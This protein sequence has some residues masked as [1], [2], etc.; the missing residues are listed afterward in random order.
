MATDCSIML[1]S[2]HVPVAPSGSFNR[3]CSSSSSSSS[4]STDSEGVNHPHASENLR[5]V[6]SPNA[7][8]CLDYG[9]CV[10]SCAA[11][12]R[13]CPLSALAAGNAASVKMEAILA[14]SPLFQGQ[15]PIFPKT[16]K[17][18]DLVLGERLGEGG[19][20][21]VYGCAFKDAPLDES[22]AIKYLRPQI[23]SQKKSFEHGAADL[24]T[25]AF[26]L[27]K[28]NHPNIIKLRA[29]TTGSVESNVC[30]GKETGFFLVVDRLV[31]TVDQRLQRWR[32]QMDHTPHSLFHRM[33][34][35]FK[36][37][38]KA[39]LKERLKVASDIASVM[40]Y[41]HSLNVGEYHESESV[42]VEC[43]H[44]LTWVVPFS[45][46]AAYRDLKPD[47][48][49]FDSKGNLKLFDLGLCKE[50]KP[51]IASKEGRYCMSKCMKV[52]LLYC[53]L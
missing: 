41:L 49:G 39:F 11:Y 31:E 33:S 14:D 7:A 8:R 5:A 23:T 46:F 18:E 10:E 17:S 25:E 47:N 13:I 15:P 30:S 24:A 22:C 51:T 19:F 2:P 38:Q 29:V 43:L 50:E 12:G 48:I 52:K 36:D 6:S 40:A 16:V 44:C 34:K 26:F 3:S 21:Y 53:V 28:L 35:E 1:L 32:E 27:A 4:T 42:A 45:I 9:K 37:N 20:C